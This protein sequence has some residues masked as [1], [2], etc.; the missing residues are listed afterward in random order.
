MVTT[1]QTTAVTGAPMNF[2]KT[3]VILFPALE[4]L[5]VTLKSLWAGIRYYDKYRHLKL[6]K[7]K[8]KSFFET[9]L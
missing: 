3:L 4:K 7:K 6:Q 5:S 8:K 1:H 2:I 9:N